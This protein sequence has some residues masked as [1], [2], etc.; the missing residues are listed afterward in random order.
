MKY[1]EYEYLWPPR[2]E[3]K[4]PPTTHAFYQKRGYWAQVKKNGTCTVIF[5]RGDEIYVLH[6]YQKKTNQAPK[7]AIDTGKRRYREAVE[8]AKNG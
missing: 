2:P 6:C 7:Q 1:T 4:V 3:R 5:A 8:L